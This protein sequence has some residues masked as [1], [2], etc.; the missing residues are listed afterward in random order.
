MPKCR[1]LG[2]FLFILTSFPIVLMA[3]TT[4]LIQ[5]YTSLA[6]TANSCTFQT[7]P[8]SAGNTEPALLELEQS[9]IKAAHS[10]SP[11]RK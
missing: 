6:D 4:T 1:L 5:Q 8:N 7:T 9:V 3:S 10:I 2:P 11:G